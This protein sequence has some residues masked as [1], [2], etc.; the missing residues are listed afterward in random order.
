MNRIRDYT[1]FA[2]WFAGLGYVALWPVSSVDP[3]GKP[4]GASIFCNDAS[5]NQLD[6]LCNSSHPLEL[7]PGLHAIGFLSAIYVMARLP[8][9]AVKRVRR[10]SR[11]AAAEPP[12]PKAQQ[13]AAL[14]PPRQPTCRT[15]TC[16]PR[17]H[18]GLRGA[19][20]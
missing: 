17:T 3:S 9:F 1:V 19:P 15:H 10:A 8:L 5:L 6:L 16:A 2:L 13:D 4:F 18:F 12:A 7:P 20:H 14:P 11:A